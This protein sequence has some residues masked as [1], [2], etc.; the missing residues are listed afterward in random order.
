MVDGSE[1]LGK[2][3]ETRCVR[4]EREGHNPTLGEVPFGSRRPGHPHVEKFHLAPK[5]AASKSRRANTVLK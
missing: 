2:Q 5:S 4:L 1:L 3:L